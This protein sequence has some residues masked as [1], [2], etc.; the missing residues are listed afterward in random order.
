MLQQTLD[1]SS[2]R[3]SYLNSARTS[4]KTVFP[5]KIMTEGLSF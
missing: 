3:K 5:A 2:H 4:T 1:L